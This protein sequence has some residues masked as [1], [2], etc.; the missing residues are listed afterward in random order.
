M[1]G[2]CDSAFAPDSLMT[3]AH[4]AISDWMSSANCAGV[5]GAGS[6]P[7]VISCSLNSGVASTAAI[8]LL[9]RAITARGVP[10]GTM[11]PYQVPAS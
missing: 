11:M 6:A 2:Y 1:P 3:F 9:S 5:F 7:A 4:L 8:S 10:A